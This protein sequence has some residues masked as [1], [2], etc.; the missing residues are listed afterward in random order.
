[1]SP[2]PGPARRC[3]VTGDGR[4]K[5]EL[6]RFVVGPDGEVVPDVEERL[7]GRG[8]WLT[9][10]RDIVERA[11]SKG[12][13]AKAARRRV[14]IPEGFS[15]RVAARLASHCLDLL[16]LA[17]RAGQAVA[18]YEKVRAAL[19]A[20]AAP[21]TGGAAVLMCAADGT[22]KRFNRSR[23]PASE[24]LLV[25]LFSG[26]DLGTVFGR[27]RVAHVLI[28]PGALADRLRIEAKRL[29]GFRQ[30]RG[31]SSLSQG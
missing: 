10:R 23:A 7:P 25:N 28:K 26:A 6:L 29:A 24:A 18:G 2:A 19:E 8:L 12:L 22:G 20:G 9:A 1:M 13:F 5:E 15:D 21:K 14:T 16:G 3:I 30:E 31:N 27:D 11:C 17:R 4:P